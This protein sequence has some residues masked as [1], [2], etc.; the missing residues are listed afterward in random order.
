MVIRKAGILNKVKKYIIHIIYSVLIILI[1]YSSYL[2]VS[3]GIVVKEDLQ[4]ML[5]LSSA[6]I[7]AYAALIA[8]PLTISVVHLSR[9]YGSPLVDVLIK[10]GKRIFLYYIVIVVVSV[11]NMIINPDTV[12]ILLSFPSM[13]TL[14]IMLMLQLSVCLLP[15][16]PLLKNLI[17]LLTITPPQIMKY[18]GYPQRIDELINK[19][20]LFEVNDMLL[21]G[22]SLIRSCI[23]DISL[24]D[25]LKDTINL[26]SIAFKNI[27]WYNKE[28]KEERMVN[29]RLKQI[30]LTS[31]LLNIV[32]A[33]DECIIDPLRNTKVLPDPYI[34]SQLIIELNRAF[35]KSEFTLT[36]F[37]EEYLKKIS[38]LV[39]IFVMNRK[40]DAL[41]LFFYSMLWS[42]KESGKSIHPR[43]ISNALILSASL[44]KKLKT[45]ASGD[46]IRQILF[47]TGQSFIAVKNNPKIFIH[48]N[49]EAIDAW[50]YLI[51]ECSRTDLGMML[52]CLPFI[53]NELEKI[54]KQE[55]KFI[56]DR[57]VRN[58]SKILT[59]IIAKLRESNWLVFIRANRLNIL[60]TNDNT[61]GSVE[62]RGILNEAEV[63]LLTLFI[64]KYIYKR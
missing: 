44:I 61:I 58:F 19:N 25:Y 13:F 45:L 20:M 35:I 4:F 9:M 27:P 56:Y 36:S 22:L 17:A 28:M 41:N 53:E 31:I 64:T 49:S 59:K 37:F 7:Q 32:R 16:Y 29:G 1:G 43:V 5:Y 39:E 14:T 33:L 40:V 21:K 34:L 30:D 26:F 54:E 12:S 18:L 60:D 55:Y 6:T 62:L 8:I 10:A 48:L 42:F 51:D 2:L 23:L 47:I 38:I 24:R 63:K 50:L 52:T 57:A 3:K 11:A 15:L 46:E